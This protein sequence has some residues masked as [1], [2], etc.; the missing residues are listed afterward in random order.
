MTIHERQK[1]RTEQKVSEQKRRLNRE[2]RNE[3]LMKEEGK[4][5]FD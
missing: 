5:G 3:E 4:E 2:K 1:T